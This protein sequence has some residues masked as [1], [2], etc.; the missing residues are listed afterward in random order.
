[1]PSRPHELGLSIPGVDEGGIFP[2]QTQIVVDTGFATLYAAGA[3]GGL[4]GESRKKTEN[5]EREEEKRIRE[6]KCVAL[7]HD[8]NSATFHNLQKCHEST[9]GKDIKDFTRDDLVIIPGTETPKWRKG[10]IPGTETPKWRK[11]TKETL[12]A[13]QP[14]IESDPDV[15]AVVIV[16]VH[17]PS[18]KH[19]KW[20]YATALAYIQIEPAWL[21]SLSFA[22]VLFPRIFPG[23]EHKETRG[24]DAYV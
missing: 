20:I 22:G 18:V 14:W 12:Q 21:Y 16:D 4:E 8:L 9:A 1:M 17:G 19:T 6:R 11:G 24:I 23:A 13:V 10:T 15:D 3:S 7:T 5:T 2:G